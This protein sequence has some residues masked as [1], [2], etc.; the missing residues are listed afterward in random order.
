MKSGFLPYGDGRLHFLDTQGPGLPVFCFHGNS[1]SAEAFADLARPGSDH[2]LIAVDLPG[3]GRSSWAT[4][5]QRAY[6][7]AGFA[8]ALR[9]A[10]D[11]FAFDEYAIIG[12]SLGGHAALE[13]LPQLPSLRALVLVGAPPFNRRTA[14]SVFLPDPSGGLVFRSRLADEEIVR[15]AAAFVH[16]APAPAAQRARIEQRI[17]ATDPQVRAQLGSS[18][19]NGAFG[20]ECGLLGTSRVPALLLQGG[21]D[22]FI[23][24]RRC[25]APASFPGCEL[26]VVLFEDCGHSPHIERPSRVRELA[27]NFINQSRKGE[28]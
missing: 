3:H 10:V 6:T 17:R 4:E 26:E 18:L 1:S 12:H 20:D 8:D 21:A 13:A 11:H 14:G 16:A 22:A 25:G 7:F 23:D 5:P 9:A 24:G 15:L 28:T 27:Y 19:G 2:R